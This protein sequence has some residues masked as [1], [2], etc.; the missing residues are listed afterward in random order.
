MDATHLLAAAAA[1]VED[2]VQQLQHAA[3]LRCVKELNELVDVLPTPYHLGLL[4]EGA[5]QPDV[6]RYMPS[7]SF[8][9]PSELQQFCF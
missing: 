6:L 5:E 2:L 3:P 1:Q 9:S 7:H 4:P 8:V